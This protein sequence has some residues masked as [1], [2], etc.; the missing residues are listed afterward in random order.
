M[1]ERTKPKFY[2]WR[3][4]C[5]SQS[6][7]NFFKLSPFAYLARLCLPTHFGYPLIT[8]S[9]YCAYS[10]SCSQNL[11]FWIHFPAYEQRTLCTPNLFPAKLHLFSLLFSGFGVCVCSFPFRGLSFLFHPCTLCN[12]VRC[13]S[14]HLAF[15]S[16][17]S[18]LEKC[19]VPVRP[20][21]LSVAILYHVSPWLNIYFC[22]KRM[23]KTCNNSRNTENSDISLKIIFWQRRDRIVKEF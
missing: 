12:S 20:F 18:A 19:A 5:C 23:D 21:G 13:V 11:Y 22:C 16:V 15:P 8:I 7:H 14:S 9:S 10:V 4:G 1:Y 17:F 3:F 2:F 6:I